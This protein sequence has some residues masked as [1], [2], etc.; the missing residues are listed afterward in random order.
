MKAYVEKRH[1]A[2][3]EEIAA[4]RRKPD[5]AKW[6]EFLNDIEWQMMLSRINAADIFSAKEGGRIVIRQLIAQQV[7]D[8]N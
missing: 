3:A 7:R 8:P 1:C 4:D 6:R 5:N 2:Q